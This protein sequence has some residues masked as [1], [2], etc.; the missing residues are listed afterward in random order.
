MSSSKL[1]HKLKSIVVVTTASSVLF[2]GYCYYTNNEKFFNHFLMPILRLMPA[3]QA[4]E[5]AVKT[6]KWKILPKNDYQDPES[7]VRKFI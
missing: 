3:E 5:A 1:F 7:L 4:H 2:G 6:F